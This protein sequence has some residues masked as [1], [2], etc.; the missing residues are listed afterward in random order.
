[1]AAE[2]LKEEQ[3]EPKVRRPWPL[4]VWPAVAITFV[5][6]G[7]YVLGT[8]GALIAAGQAVATLIFVGGDL[9]YE[10]EKRRAI[11]V[12]AVAVATLVVTVLLWQAQVPWLA[13]PAGP[14]LTGGGTGPVDLRGRTVTAK[15]IRGLDLRGAQL[16]GATFDDGIDLRGRHLEGVVAAGASFQ[17]AKLSGA[18]LRG[19][20]LHGADLSRACLRGADITGADLIGAE[21]SGAD[22]HGL[23]LPSATTRTIRGKPA[24][25]GETV[26]GCR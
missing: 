7:G 13:R 16:S 10:G 5:A 20:D 3:P 19:A 1:M 24:R 15:T 21:L 14:G 26:A 12:T 8:L 22:L 18:A 25:A 9:L 17:G 11:A 4:W 2:K 6:V 23:R